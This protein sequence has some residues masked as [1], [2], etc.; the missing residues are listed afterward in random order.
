MLSGELVTLNASQRYIFPNLGP[1][2]GD[3]GQYFGHLKSRS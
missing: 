1:Q 3:T 2:V